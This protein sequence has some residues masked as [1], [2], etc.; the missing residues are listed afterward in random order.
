MATIRLVPSIQ[1][2][3][4]ADFL[5]GASSSTLTSNTFNAEYYRVNILT[6]LLPLRPQVD[7]R[8]L[9]IY[10]DSARTHA[11]R[12]RRDFCEENRLHLAVHPRYSHNLTPSDFFLFGQIKHCLQGIAFP[13]RRQLLTAIQEIV[14]AIP[15]PPLEEVFRHWMERLEWVSQ[16]NG[17]YYPCQLPSIS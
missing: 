11:T 8:R 14:G 13:S 6:G 17:D 10:V 15:Q 1:Q 9:V 12:K 16:D 4:V 5:L 7:G 3:I 2:S